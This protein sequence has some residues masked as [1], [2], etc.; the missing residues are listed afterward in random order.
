MPSRPWFAQLPAVNRWLLGSGTVCLALGLFCLVGVPVLGATGSAVQAAYYP[1][2]QAG[3]QE[4]CLSNLRHIGEAL[5]QYRQD[6]DGRFPLSEY[7]GPSNGAK[8]RFTW[9]TVLQERGVDTAT[10]TCPTGRPGDGRATGSYGINPVFLG[11]ALVDQSEVETGGSMLLADR[12]ELHDVLLF[13]PFASWP[14]EPKAEET[15]AADSVA[16][17]NIDY[18]HSL[19]GSSQ[20]T[21]LYADGHAEAHSVGSWSDEAAS[22]GGRMLLRASRER[23]EAR[24]PLLKK[25]KAGSPRSFRSQKARLRLALEPL[26]HLDRQAHSNNLQDETLQKR[27]WKGAGLLRSVGDPALE[28]QLARELDAEAGS[29]LRGSGDNTD[30]FENE[31]GFTL[32]YPAGWRTETQTDGRYRTSYF[33]S[34]SPY[35]QVLVERGERREPTSATTIDFSGMEDG[36]KEKYGTGYK[37]LKM[38]RSTLGGQEV[39]LWECELKKPDGPKLHKRYLGHSS[40]WN[41]TILVCTAP[42]GSWQGAAP[43]WEQMNDSFTFR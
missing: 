37:R 27:L 38:G 16:T 22:W 36:L 28:A 35:L 9:V 6:Y 8:T 15:F 10:F 18:R 30:L 12:G 43:L 25:I 17:H 13:P 26:H 33:R 3:R 21:V 42:A 39:S 11:R 32:R 7:S 20:A 31:S 24:Y 1:Y 14:I 5:A 19:S 41:S 40:M 34:P 4:T 23:L 29:I 2:T